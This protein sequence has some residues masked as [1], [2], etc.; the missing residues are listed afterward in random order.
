MSGEGGCVH[1]RDLE[2][3]AHDEAARYPLDA[4]GR[5]RVKEAIARARCVLG[6]DDARLHARL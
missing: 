5:R 4:A 1:W 6:G 3:Q 2:D